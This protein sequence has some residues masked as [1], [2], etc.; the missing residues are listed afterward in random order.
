MEL[1]AVLTETIFRQSGR[2]E[3]KI[4]APSKDENHR[5]SIDIHPVNY[6][7]NMHRVS[8]ARDFLLSAQISNYHRYLTA[9]C[10]SEE[11]EMARNEART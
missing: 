4:F 8:G 11:V 6:F 5:I 2:L 7:P 9:H 3:L 10:G 1:V